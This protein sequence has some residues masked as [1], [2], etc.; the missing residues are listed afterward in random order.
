[1]YS[2]DQNDTVIELHDAPQS[3]VGAPCPIVF[4]TEHTIFLA[5][6]IQ[7]T[8]KGWDGLTVRVVDE[9]TVG[10]PV[11]L[12]NFTEPYAH[13]FGPPNDEAFSGHP[14]ASRGLQPYSINEIRGSSWIRNLERMNSV[15]PYHKP[16]HF[17][18]YR[19]FVFAFHDTTF[20]CIADGFTISLHVGSVADVAKLACKK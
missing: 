13:M 1:M 14:L 15:H 18:D 20:E 3:S 7:N 19:H 2:I 5:Y 10:K 8:P 11:A 12:V 17:A 4:A 9:N 6:Y 16:E